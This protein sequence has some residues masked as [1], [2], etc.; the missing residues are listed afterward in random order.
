MT[1][2]TLLIALASVLAVTA[3]STSC[4][5][6][7]QNAPF[8]VDKPLPPPPAGELKFAGSPPAHAYAKQAGNYFSRTVY[9]T[10]GPGTTH[11]EVRDVL[12]PPHS[13]ASVEAFPGPVVADPSSGRAT[14]SIGGKPE[15]LEPGTARSLP[16]GQASTFENSDPGPAMVRLYVIRAR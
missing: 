8:V 15:T 16:A 11:I 13:K 1:G 10:D 4:Q 6:S 14:V 2:R 9:E 5:R 7:A 3:G 12:I